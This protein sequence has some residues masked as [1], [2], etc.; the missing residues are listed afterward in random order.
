LRSVV[1]VSSHA[2]PIIQKAGQVPIAL[3][4][5]MRASMRPRVHDRLPLVVTRAD[6]W[7][8]SRPAMWV[9]VEK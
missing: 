6:R 8:Q 9:G 1:T 4:I 7:Y 5:A 2:V 3:G